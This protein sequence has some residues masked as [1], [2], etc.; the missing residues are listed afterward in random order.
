TL[1][2]RERIEEVRHNQPSSFGREDHASASAHCA[3][4]Q[5]FRWAGNVLLVRIRRGVKVVTLAPIERSWAQRI[6]YAKNKIDVVG[7]PEKIRQ[8]LCCQSW[9]CDLVDDVCTVRRHN[10]NFHAPLHGHVA[11]C[12]LSAG[13]RPRV[14][15]KRN[16]TDNDYGSCKP[17]SIKLIS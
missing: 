15:R 5:D 3:V 13:R 12:E 17:A 6:S 7:R 11:A 4:D 9:F 8:G 1:N 2:G 10:H 14:E 16:R